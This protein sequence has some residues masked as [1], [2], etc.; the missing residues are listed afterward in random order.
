MD[1]SFVQKEL[2]PTYVL[3]KLINGVCT[4]NKLIGIGL[5]DISE[6]KRQELVAT[7]EKLVL[8]EAKEFKHAVETKDKVELLD[9]V[10]DTLVVGSY[11][12][13]LNGENF[14]NLTYLEQDQPLEHYAEWFIK[15]FDNKNVEELFY[16][17]S[18]IFFKL[19]VNHEKAVDTVLESN[20]S[21]FPTMCQLE[22]IIGDRTPSSLIAY[23][24]TLIESAGRYTGV[25]CKKV[26]DSEGGERLTFWA[27]HDNGEEKL[28]YVKP[29][30]YTDP[31]FAECFYQ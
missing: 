22:N 30:T 6:E 14:D 10:V 8:E 19:Q 17:A 20:L 11:Y 2:D 13:L 9:A 23:Q 7:Y 21:K 12:L 29:E 26:V 5:D 18:E 31:L 24:C 25:H 1:L 4:T 27:T 3:E 16:L 28:K 15:G